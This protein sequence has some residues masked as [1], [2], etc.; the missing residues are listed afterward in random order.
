MAKRTFTVSDLTGEPILSHEEVTTII[1]HDAPGLDHAVTLDAGKT[2]L[3]GLTGS[4]K[5]YVLLELVSDGGDSSERM[6]VEATAFNKLFKGDVGEVLAEAEHYSYGGKAPEEPKKRG[7][8]AKAAGPKPEKTDYTTIEHAGKP[9][10][11]RLTDAEKLQVQ[12]NLDKVNANLKAASI[13]EIDLTD[14]KMVEKYDL[15][16]LAQDRGIVPK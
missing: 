4:K 12:Q 15:Y 13:R 2:E 1:V 10:R 6:V 11:G 7:R 3:K 16:K 9:H 5:E 8:P 14:A